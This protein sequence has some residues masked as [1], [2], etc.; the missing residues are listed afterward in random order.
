MW[1]FFEKSA[2]FANGFASHP[3]ESGALAAAKSRKRHLADSSQFRNRQISRNIDGLSTK[4]AHFLYQ[5]MSDPLR[6][7]I[8]R[9]RRGADFFKSCLYRCLAIPETDG[10]DADAPHVFCV[11]LPIPISTHTL[12]VRRSHTLTMK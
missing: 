7:L 4:N 6:S 5:P 8:Y 12:P 10:R 1:A 3:E 11:I 2:I 9:Y